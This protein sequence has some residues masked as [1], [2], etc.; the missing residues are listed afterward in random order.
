MSNVLEGLAKELAPILAQQQARQFG[1]GYKHDAPGTPITTG[2][3]DIYS[4]R[5]CIN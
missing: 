3:Y 4:I 5:L 1:I 2:S